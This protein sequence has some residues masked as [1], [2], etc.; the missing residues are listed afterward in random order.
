MR[1]L[2]LGRRQS[3]QSCQIRRIERSTVGDPFGRFHIHRDAGK[4]LVIE[5]VAKRFATQVAFADVFVPVDS[6]AEFALA[7][8]QMKGPNAVDADDLD[9]TCSIVAA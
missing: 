1:G 9:R 4:A 8:V 2:A 3:A 6:A 5:D 7:V